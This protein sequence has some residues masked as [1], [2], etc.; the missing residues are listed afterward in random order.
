MEPCLA[1]TGQE[2]AAMDE[3]SFNEAAECTA[4]FARV[5]PQQK[6]SW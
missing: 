6:L 4:V 2:M 1:L 3:E 5:S